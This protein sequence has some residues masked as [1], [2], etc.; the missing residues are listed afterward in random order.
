M[1]GNH[2]TERPNRAYVLF[3]QVAADC[4]P[5]KVL[6]QRSLNA[7]YAPILDVRPTTLSKITKSP[8]FPPFGVF[9]QLQLVLPGNCM[10]HPVSRKKLSGY[11]ELEYT[12]NTYESL[13]QISS[14]SSASSQWEPGRQTADHDVPLRSSNNTSLA[15]EAGW[16]LT[17]NDKTSTVS[18]FI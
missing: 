7:K 6:P 2:R 18:T 5:G 10:Q 11:A 8:H 12:C 15:A 13:A 17:G 4:V 3:L 1:K 16:S 9:Y 14:C